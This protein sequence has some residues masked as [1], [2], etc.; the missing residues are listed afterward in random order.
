MIVDDTT[1]LRRALARAVLDD[2]EDRRGIKAELL[3]VR[4]YDPQTYVEIS[5]AIAHAIMGVI[6]RFASEEA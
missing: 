5:V 1:E 2:L 4:S 3:H 6:E